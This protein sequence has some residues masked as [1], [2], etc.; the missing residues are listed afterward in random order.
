MTNRK[1]RRAARARSNVSRIIQQTQTR[2]PTKRAATIFG[3]A[4]EEFIAGEKKRL[5]PDVPLWLAMA[6]LSEGIG[7][8]V[9]SFLLMTT[10]NQSPKD[11]IKPMLSMIAMGAKQIIEWGEKENIAAQVREK[12]GASDDDDAR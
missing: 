1:Q 8:A 6:A 11:G 5:G 7:T 3:G 4:L 9:G 10:H 12:F 2:E